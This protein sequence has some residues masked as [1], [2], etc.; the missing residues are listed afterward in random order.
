[1]YG[2]NFF[3]TIYHASI[4]KADNFVDLVLLINRPTVWPTCVLRLQLRL[5]D[6][7]RIREEPAGETSD[8]SCEELLVKVRR[9][10][11]RL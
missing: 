4:R 3:G 9:G 5:D 8:A 10:V 11:C 6:V 2:L 1:M 7:L